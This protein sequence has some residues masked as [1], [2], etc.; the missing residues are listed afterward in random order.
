MC[1]S[2]SKLAAVEEDGGVEGGLSILASSR[3]GRDT[4]ENGGRQLARGRGQLVDGGAAAR[5]KAGLLKKVGGRIAADGEF[6][7]DRKARAQSAARRLAATIFSR[8]PV[9]SPTVGSI[10]ASAIFTIPV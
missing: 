5:Q 1:C 7:E 10:W 8:F 9:K 4:G 3:A 6:G 2:R